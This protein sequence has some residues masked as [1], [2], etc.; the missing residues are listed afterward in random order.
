MWPRLR[1]A[2]FTPDMGEPDPE[3]DRRLEVISIPADADVCIF[4]HRF[5]TFANVSKYQD[6]LHLLAT[7][8]TEVSILAESPLARISL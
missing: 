4:G 6:P 8:I 5:L 1:A 2:G 7:H 3:F